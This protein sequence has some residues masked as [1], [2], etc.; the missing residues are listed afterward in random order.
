MTSLQLELP[1]YTAAVRTGGIPTPLVKVCSAPG[2][3]ANYCRAPG[4]VLSRPHEGARQQPLPLDTH[5]GPRQLIVGRRPVIAQQVEQGRGV[6]HL[7]QRSF[8]AAL[9]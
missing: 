7:S 5:S 6:G 8:Q 1:A 9:G 4:A 3:N 2:V